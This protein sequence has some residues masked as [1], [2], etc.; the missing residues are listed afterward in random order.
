MIEKKFQQV[1]FCKKDEETKEEL[2][3]RVG[4]Q[5]KLLLEAGYIAVVRYDEPALGII[6]IEF[7]HNEYIEGAYGNAMPIWLS[8]EEQDTVIWD[9]ERGF[10]EN[11]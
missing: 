10:D 8:S 3:N 6:V 9:D 4:E 11:E 2:F 7:E 1:V 5:L